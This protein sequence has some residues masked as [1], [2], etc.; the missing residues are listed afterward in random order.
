MIYPKNNSKLFLPRNLDGTN[1]QIVFK[2]AH[3][4]QNEGQKLPDQIQLKA[5]EYHIYSNIK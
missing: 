4:R 3:A 2:L 5:W 1:N